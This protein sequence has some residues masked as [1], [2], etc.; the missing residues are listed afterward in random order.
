MRRIQGIISMMNK[1]MMISW[2]SGILETHS[3]MG[4]P[5]GSDGKESACSEGDLG[6]IP[7]LGR[8][9][10]EGNGYPVPF[11]GLENS[12]DCIVI[13]AAKSWTQSS[14]IEVA[15]LKYWWTTIC[16]PVPFIIK[17]LNWRCWE[18]WNLMLRN[19]N[20]LLFSSFKMTWYFVLSMHQFTI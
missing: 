15:N 9:P 11:S 10:G 16:L 6:L 3:V 17:S 13:G 2:H 14:M 12:M 4:F 7:G 20:H 8:S 18:S 19:S 5:G 1:W